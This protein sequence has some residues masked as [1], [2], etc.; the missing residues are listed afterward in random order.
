MSE[1]VQLNVGS[2]EDM[3]KRF[4]SAW[5]RLEQ[6]EA[7]KETHL[8]FFDWDAMTSSLSPKRLELLRHLHAHPEK[9]VSS[10]ARALK[11]DYKRVHEDVSLLEHAGLLFRDGAFIT[12]PYDHLQ[13]TVSLS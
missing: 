5:H 7:V 4:I 10:L 13:A 9:S 12:T 1:T 8:T 6:G 2:I 3:G 11:R